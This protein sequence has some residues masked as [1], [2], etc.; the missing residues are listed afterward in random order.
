MLL[1]GTPNCRVTP[2]TS[3]GWIRD[4]ECRWLHRLEELRCRPH[5]LPS[6]E[7]QLGN[8]I[9]KDSEFL[10]HKW[11]LK[12][13][14]PCRRMRD[15]EGCAPPATEASSPW[16]FCTINLN[17]EK[18][19]W[20]CEWLD[21]L[22][23]KHHILHDYPCFYTLQET[24]NWTTSSING[25]GYIVYGTDLGRTAICAHGRLVIF[26]AHGLIMKDAPPFWWARQCCFQ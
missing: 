8:S 11:M 4:C 15:A 16:L 10:L 3:D 12:R 6:Q 18:G 14:R 7:A 17:R 19:E 23:H 9:L 20:C 13:F 26:V 5:S 22:R 25:P 24:D 2:S 21:D 1:C